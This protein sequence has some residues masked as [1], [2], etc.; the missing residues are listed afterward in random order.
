MYVNEPSLVVFAYIVSSDIIIAMRLS[1][2]W[3]AVA[4]F[5]IASTSE[6]ESIDDGQIVR[7]F[8]YELH[9]STLKKVAGCVVLALVSLIV[10]EQISLVIKKGQ[11]R[12]PRF[13]IP[14]IGSI[15]ELVNHPYTFWIKQT[16]WGAGTT[17]VVN[18]CSC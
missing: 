17:Y 9:V 16:S 18:L 5:T 12:G 2:L 1:L 4:I 7:G 11:F 15:L 13:T 10:Y 3:C 6:S 8:A 14:F